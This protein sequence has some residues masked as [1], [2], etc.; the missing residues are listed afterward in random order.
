MRAA[1][2][3]PERQEHG[4]LLVVVNLTVVKYLPPVWQE[5]AL[6]PGAVPCLEWYHLSSVWQEGIPPPPS[7]MPPRAAKVFCRIWQEVPAPQ[8]A[9]PGAAAP[10][11]GTA[12]TVSAA[13]HEAH[14]V[15]SGASPSGT[16]GTR[17]PGGTGRT[18][19]KAQTPP[20]ATAGTAPQRADAPPGVNHGTRRMKGAMPPTPGGTGKSPKTRKKRSE[21]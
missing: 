21:P 8:Q 6:P 4:R 20:A 2:P 1:L 17:R 12:G 10:P 11:P 19:A 9:A 13:G 14:S 16:A 18:P 15:T 7:P 5:R 3:P